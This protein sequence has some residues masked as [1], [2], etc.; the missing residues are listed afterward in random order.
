MYH[1]IE[2]EL[3]GR[4]LSIETGRMAK[5]ADG[6]CVV[7]YGDTMVLVTAVGGK[8][9]TAMDFF[10]LTVD[11]IEKSY[12]AGKIPGGFIKREGR[13][14]SE[15]VLAARMI[16]RPIR[17][18]FEDDFL[19][20]VQIVVNVIS[21]DKENEA[22]ILG[23]IGA[24]QALML[25]G[26]PFH[27]PVAG[28]RVGYINDEIVINPTNS[29][30]SESK[31]DMI[32][33]G[34]EKAVTMVEGFI[35]KLPEDIVLKGI[36]DAHQVIKDICDFQN[37]LLSLVP[38]EPKKYEP[39]LVPEKLSEIIE[40]KAGERIKESC[41]MTDKL[42]RAAFLANVYDEVASFIL[43]ENPDE[44]PRKIAAAFHDVEKKYVRNKFINEKKRVDGRD[45]TQ[46]RPISIDMSV[47]P[48]AH[49]SA[50]FT[51]GETQ[52]LASVTLGTAGDMQVLDELKG[53]TKKRFM[54]HY[55]FPPFSVN[56]VKR[57]GSPGR[58]EIGHGMLAE[59]ALIPIL[60][61]E[62]DFPYTIRIVSDILE[63]NGSSSMA[64]VCGGSLALMDAGVPVSEAVAG[65]AMGLIKEKDDFIILTDIMGLE[66]HLGDMDF[67]VAGT[68]DY[69]TAIQM[70]IKIEG[71][72]KEI[73]ER[74]LEQAKVGRLHILGIMNEAM[75]EP[76]KELSQYAPGII[77]VKVPVDSIAEI[78]GPGGK[79]IKAMSAE[80]DCEI[81][82]SEDGTV[83]VSSQNIEMAK[84]AAEKIKAMTHV[85][86][87]GE[88]VEGT[89]AKIMD[90]GAFLDLDGGKSAL[91]HISE[92]S[93]ERIG[94]VTDVLK[95]GDRVKAK[96]IKIDDHGRI[97]VSVKKM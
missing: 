3:L 40:E 34:T 64:S 79:N 43:E 89:V 13:P 63:S 16:D 73:M 4:K 68:K 49:G 67:K 11:Y 20:E 33:A 8:K 90:F 14:S 60:P 65:V 30:L 50:L 31:M 23:I 15:E 42:K 41:Y 22:D 70:D 86:E 80:Y 93:K 62:E 59:R 32:V 94:K 72:T 91:L 97:N 69:I 71:V 61:K 12:S 58:R 54:L 53:E 21:A 6:S 45:F 39:F 17:P 18:L 10:P 74:A 85:Y 76:R 82:I 52:A 66:D 55:N 26:L 24:S 81:W 83:Q 27:G 2:M 88:I 37:K 56:E 77:L 95:E 28:V 5:Q 19:N 44:D 29:Q 78:I 46:V 96:I 25:S 92:I 51:R 35:D 75:S 1:T 47:L 36:L 7:R 38:V 57:L 87:V 9:Q 84:K 48:R